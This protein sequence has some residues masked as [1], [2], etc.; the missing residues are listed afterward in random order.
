MPFC[1]CPLRRSRRGVLPVTY[2]VLSSRSVVRYPTERSATIIGRGI[3]YGLVSTRF[4]TGLPSSQ[5]SEARRQPSII[6]QSTL[7]MRK[8]AKMEPYL[9][10]S[11]FASL[12]NIRGVPPGNATGH[13]RDPPRSLSSRGSSALALSSRGRSSRASGAHPFIR[14]RR[15]SRLREA[16]FMF[17]ERSLRPIPLPR[18]APL[19]S[20]VPSTHGRCGPCP[21]RRPRRVPRVPNVASHRT[22]EEGR[23]RHPRPHLSSCA[24][25]SGVL[26]VHAR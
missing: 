26:R 7:P 24:P 13:L 16:R 23:E 12:W 6:P 17:R 5:R 22:S 25:R 9:H 3:R 19:A 8:A 2:A 21:Q 20:H 15:L 4:T 11:N 10:H 1:P 18:A 14:P